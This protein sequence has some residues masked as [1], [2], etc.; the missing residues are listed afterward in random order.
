MKF[1]YGTLFFLSV[2]SASGQINIMPFAE[3]AKKGFTYRKL[4]SLYRD[5]ARFMKARKK[6]M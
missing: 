3:A 5:N 2:I 4:D 1:I 6:N